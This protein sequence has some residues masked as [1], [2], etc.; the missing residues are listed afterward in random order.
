MRK[1]AS[2]ILLL[3]LLFN[4]VG[5]RAWF[6]YAE[7][8][9]DMAMEGRL[10]KAQYN[11]NEL[12]TLSIPLRNPYQLEQKSFERVNG[13]ISFEGKIFKYVKRRITDG[14][15]VILCIPDNHKMILK[16]AKSAFGNQ[17]NDM[18]NNPNKNSS[19]N[20]QKNFNGSDYEANLYKF[21]I[22][23]VVSTQTIQN[24]SLILSLLDN[25]MTAPGKPP[26]FRA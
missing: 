24:G 19:H 14:N 9:A 15:L 16:N 12:V 13:E 4:M 7:Q 3:I 2:I 6:Y 10:D 1:S 5:Y 17:A 22:P 23:L 8:K 18:T 26:E 20:A 25:H 11:E 21:H